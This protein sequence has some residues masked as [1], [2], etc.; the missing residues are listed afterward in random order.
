[1]T[2]S[3]QKN[4]FEN[5]G[6]TVPIQVVG[7]GID[8]SIWN[9][10]HYPVTDDI[11]STTRKITWEDINVEGHYDESDLIFLSVFKWKP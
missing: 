1:M 10:Q 7:Q 9:T 6:V 4:I 5:G 11:G 2:S 3:F 8:V